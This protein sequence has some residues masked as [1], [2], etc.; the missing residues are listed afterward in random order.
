MKIVIS[1]IPINI[2]KKNIKNMHLQIK[3]PDGHVVISVPLSMDDKAIEVYARTNLSW[4]K[5]QIEKFQQ[6]SRSSKRQYV[7][8][9]TMYVW[10]KQY[11]LYFVPDSK[12]NSF[13][14]DGDK[15]ILSMRVDSTVE[16]REKYV[17]EQHRLL[18]KAEIEKFLAK[19][20]KITGIYCKSWQTKYMVT[21]WGTCNIEKKKLWF[22]LQLTQKP[23]ECLEYVILHELIHLKERTHNSTFIG[24]MD[25]YMKN[26][27]MVR[28]ELNDL[29]L[30]YYDAQRENKS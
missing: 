9:E 24:Y 1:G 18:L 22:N 23:I 25:M 10:G 7:S 13:K 8:G 6:Q 16:Q 5:K 26:W 4:I 2:Q 15:V 27:R 21:R 19:W 20:E 3:P 28:K 14:I 17:R 30:D 12:K 11:Y 29:R